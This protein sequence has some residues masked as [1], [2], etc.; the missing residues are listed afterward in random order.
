MSRSWRWAAFQAAA[1]FIVAAG[2][3]QAEMGP[4]V[5]PQKKLIGWACDRI[6]TGEMHRSIAELEQHIPFDG[7][8][9]TVRPDAKRDADGRYSGWFGGKRHTRADFKQAIADLEATNCKRFTDNFID[10][11]TTVR[12]DPAPGEENLDWFDPNWSVIANNGAIAAHIAK[13]GRLKGLF[14]D[15]EHYP[16]GVGPWQHP[17]DY[18]NYALLTEAAGETPRSFEQCVKQIRKRGGEFMR[19]VTGVYPDITIVMITD[20]GWG[21]GPLV[22]A[23]VEG[24]LEIRGRATLVDGAE[25]AYRMNTYGEMTGMIGR[26]RSIQAGN[27][28]KDM[29]RGLG[30]WW[31]TR[32]G[33]DMARFSGKRI[34]DNLRDPANVEHTLHN[35]LTAADRY[36]WVFSFG[37]YPGSVWWHHSYGEAPDWT[38]PIP[39]AY[40]DA[41]RNCRE[42]HDLAWIPGG[43]NPHANFDGV[44]LVVGDKVT[45]N[46]ANLLTNGDFTLWPSG[47]DQ[48]PKGWTLIK[49]GLQ[50]GKS[51]GVKRDDAS[52]KLGRYS[53]QLGM[54]TL[55][56]TGHISLDQPVPAK[57]IAGKTVTFGAWIKSND[58][59]TGN[60]EI[61]GVYHGT[62]STVSPPDEHGWRFHTMTAPI[63][64]DMKGEVVFRLRA[65]IQY[66]PEE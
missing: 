61:V 32:T 66:S 9:I 27:L 33:E 64:A 17:F 3:A 6:N 37:A 62:T 43:K 11:E 21:T 53:P 13:Q 38:V 45:D 56:D 18:K 20:T 40:I 48:A 44:V 25:Q 10:F 2:V 35:A 29:E 52:A 7:I 28:Y 14:I 41:F 50:S 59:D 19:A 63:P 57:D 46:A 42:P 60:L 54:A 51:A 30:I 47:P 65:F 8:V 5:P 58:T 31:D 55:G 39:Q 34:E 23:F 16:G 1:L 15:V 4:P 36:V 12:H 26:A 49:S 24:M 22:A